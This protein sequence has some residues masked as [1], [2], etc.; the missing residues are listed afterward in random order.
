[1]RTILAVLL[2]VLIET[3]ILALWGAR[4]GDELLVVVSANV[5]TNLT[6]SLFLTLVSS[7]ALIPVVLLPEAAV[8]AAE[9]GIFRLAFGRRRRLFAVTLAANVLSFCLGLLLWPLLA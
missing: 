7:A 6:L 8:T 4:K 3:P 2:T 5:V 1:M 9:Y